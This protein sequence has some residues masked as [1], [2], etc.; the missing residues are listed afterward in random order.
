MLAMQLF[1]FHVDELTIS[2]INSLLFSKPNSDNT[3]YSSVGIEPVA[4]RHRLKSPLDDGRCTHP[5]GCRGTAVCPFL[6]RKE[7]VRS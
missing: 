3:L 4:D 7:K 2:L 1:P 6:Q 5:C